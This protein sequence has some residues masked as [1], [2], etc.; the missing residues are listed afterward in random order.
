MSSFSDARGA[1]QYQVWHFWKG[2]QGA[3]RS[4]R[5]D[6]HFWGKKN[7]VIVLKCRNLQLH[8]VRGLIWSSTSFASFFFPSIV[9]VRSGQLLFKSF[10]LYSSFLSFLSFSSFF[11]N[12]NRCDW[13]TSCFPS[14]WFPINLIS[15]QVAINSNFEYFGKIN[16]LFDFSNKFNYSS[17]VDCFLSFPH[18]LASRT[19]PALQMIGQHLPFIRCRNQQVTIEQSINLIHLLPS[20][21]ERVFM[22]EGSLTTPP[23]SETVTWYIL[24]STMAVSKQTVNK[25]S[26]LNLNSHSVSADRVH[27]FLF[28]R[29]NV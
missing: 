5:L 29:S 8:T 19:A 3:G 9:S 27:I 13:F 11:L 6:S 16:F 10:L 26:M 15:L 1:F 22:Y 23:C 28:I 7:W 20:K 14:I 17:Y 12:V 25:I 4:C 2:K 24:E 18:Q 21:V